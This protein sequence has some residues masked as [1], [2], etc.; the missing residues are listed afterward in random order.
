MHK[1]RNPCKS[2]SKPSY[3]RPY[4][5]TARSDTACRPKS[6]S[7]NDPFM[8]TM[9]ILRHLHNLH[10]LDMKNILMLYPDSFYSSYLCFP[11][12]SCTCIAPELFSHS[13]LHIQDTINKMIITF[14]LSNYLNL[15]HLNNISLHLKANHGSLRFNN[16]LSLRL[17]NISMC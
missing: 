14:H 10:N 1:S 2:H 13:R 8:D 16:Y 12:R 6:L 3:M 7:H 9:H 17:V 11:D 15:F 5:C 4:T